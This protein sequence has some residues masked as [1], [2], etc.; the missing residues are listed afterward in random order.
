MIVLRMAIAQSTHD[1]L[2][3]F[4]GVN[5]HAILGSLLFTPPGLPGKQASLALVLVPALASLLVL[6]GEVFFACGAFAGEAG[7]WLGVGFGCSAFPAS[8]FCSKAKGRVQ[9]QL[10]S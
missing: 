9:H 4:L 8:R 5:S 3:H 10:K 7:R 1:A 2:G 6:V